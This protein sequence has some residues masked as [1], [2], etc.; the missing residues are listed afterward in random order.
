[1]D[2]Q[3]KETLIQLAQIAKEAQ[4]QSGVL[5]S[6]ITLL[7]P[8]AYATIEKMYINDRE[9]LLYIES[10]LCELIDNLNNHE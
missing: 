7:D 9:A 2:Y 10:T 8:Q 3:I 6:K 4:Q 5:R 1:M